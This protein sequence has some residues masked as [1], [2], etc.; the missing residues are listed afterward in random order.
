MEV[1]Q[2]WLPKSHWILNKSTKHSTIPVNTSKCVFSHQHIWNRNLTTCTTK[3][4]LLG[5]KTYAQSTCQ[6]PTH[7]VC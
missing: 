5:P 7:A 4:L 2:L 1:H 6:G 3:L